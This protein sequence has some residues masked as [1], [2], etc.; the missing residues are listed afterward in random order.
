M[1]GAIIVQKQKG[2]EEHFPGY[3]DVMTAEVV[4]E[5]TENSD[6]KPERA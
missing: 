3:T 4:T 1:R 6:K 2:A 5:F